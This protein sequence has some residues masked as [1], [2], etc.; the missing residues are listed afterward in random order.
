[1]QRKTNLHAFDRFRDFISNIKPASAILIGFVLVVVLGYIDF[2]SGYEILIS[3]FYLLPIFIASWTDNIWG[4]VSIAVLAAITTQLVNSLAGEHFS[5]PFIPYWNTLARLVIFVTVGVLSSRLHRSL[6]EEKVL[7]RTDFLTETANNRAFYEKANISLSNTRRLGKPLTV[8][9]IDIDNFKLIN[10]KYGHNTGDEMLRKVGAVIL[11]NVRTS[12][13]AARI[14]GDEFALLFPQ[15]T[16]TAADKVASKIVDVL[17]K[18]MKKNRW[19]VTFSIGVL[20][21]TKEYPKSVDEMIN[22][23]DRIMYLVKE[24]GKNGIR[25]DKA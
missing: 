8:M 4:G 16:F 25:H 23:V 17:K 14:G 18:E 21:F 9:Y 2:I 20:T 11:Q 13:T 1:M 3:L 7:S 6:E 24:N 22:S 15:T 5:N 19:A 12:D 10:D